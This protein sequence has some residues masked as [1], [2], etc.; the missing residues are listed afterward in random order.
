MKYKAIQ[1]WLKQYEPLNSWIYFNVTPMDTGTVA[2]NSVPDS[3]ITVT[4]HIDGSKEK[5]MIF[6]IVL[7]QKYSDGT[8]GLNLK[9]M[10]E[11]E[12][13][14]DWIEEQDITG[15]YPEFENCK[16]WEVARKDS[17]PTVS[18]DGDKMLA[19]YQSQFEISYLEERRKKQNGEIE[20]EPVHT[21]P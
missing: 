10:E 18:V 9:A 5:K 11:Y 12:N 7:V 15:N 13:L 14:A 6:A 21:V 4:E 20:K 17:S 19:K 1:E 8:D 2:V 16:V 3:T